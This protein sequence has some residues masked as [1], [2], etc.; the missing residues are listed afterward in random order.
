MDLTPASTPA[1]LHKKLLMVV[2]ASLIALAP[3]AAFAER[4]TSWKVIKNKSGIIVK[5]KYIPNYTLPV[6]RGESTI[7]ANIYDILAVINDVGKSCKWMADCKDTRILTKRSDFDLV[8]YNRTGTPWPLDDRDVIVQTSIKIDKAKKSVLIDFYSINGHKGK[9]DGVVRMPTFRG[10]YELEKIDDDKTRIV[11]QAQAD[12]GGNI[13]DWI[14]EIKS[15]SIPFDTIKALR[16]RVYK[17]RK[18]DEY[19]DF[20]K[21]WDP[22][23]GGQG[24]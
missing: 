9:V 14:A 11:Y 3:S 24:F 15:E 5:K 6:I 13:P 10:K 4:N 19:K 23:Q 7:S 21:K 18:T 16:D 2:M 1:P 17:T 20:I 22:K 12:V 8:V